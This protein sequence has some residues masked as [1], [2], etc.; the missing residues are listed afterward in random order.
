MKIFY[1]ILVCIWLKLMKLKKC[2]LLFYPPP[3]NFQYK[4]IDSCNYALFFTKKLINQTESLKFQNLWL[5][6]FS[7]IKKTLTGVKWESGK[8]R[9]GLIIIFV[10]TLKFPV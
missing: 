4:M 2:F 10:Y 9:F 1:S 8:V 6:S 5:S 7:A 3:T